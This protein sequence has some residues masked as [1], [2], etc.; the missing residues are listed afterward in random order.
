MVAIAILIIYTV[1]CMLHVKYVLYLL[2]VWTA[3]FEREW[4]YCW[5]CNKLYSE[6]AV[7]FFAF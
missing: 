2:S 3:D 6:N 7:I 4:M 1:S 5:Q